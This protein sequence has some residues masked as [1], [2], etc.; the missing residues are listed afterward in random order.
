MRRFLLL[1]I[2]CS[3]GRSNDRGLDPIA[4]E[5]C[6]LGKL[7]PSG[8]C[9]E[10]ISL[11][12]STQLRSQLLQGGL[13]DAEYG[14]ARPWPAKVLLQYQGSQS[15]QH[16][17]GED[18]HDSLGQQ[19]TAI[20]MMCT[21]LKSDIAEREPS[22]LPQVD[23]IAAMLREAVAQTRSMARGLVPVKD[24]PEALWVSLVEL[25]ERTDALGRTRC[26]FHCPQPVL[27]DDNAVA[28]HLYRIAQEAVNNALKHGGA[29]HITIGLKQADGAIE[30]TIADD[31]HGLAKTKGA[32]MG[33]QVMKH[34]AEMIGG[35]LTLESK[36]G[37]GVTITCRVPAHAKGKGAAA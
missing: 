35:E 13:H 10:D 25:A 5:N 3:F 14:T 12:S 36:P 20:E 6:I 34:R 19:L 18:L 29:R 23:R 24:E 30:L 33:L 32:G 4:I 15:E 16:R 9:N 21:S 8:S 17:I 7:D 11:D 22:L 27:V 2:L 26:R 37:R 31:G 1:E 28:G